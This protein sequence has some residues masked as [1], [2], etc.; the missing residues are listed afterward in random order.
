[1]Q[2]VLSYQHNI[3]NTND[4]FP[5]WLSTLLP[6]HLYD[7]VTDKKIT[8]VLLTMLLFYPCL[9]LLPKKLRFI[10]HLSICLSFCLQFHV[11]TAHRIFMKILPEMYL[12]TRKNWLNFV[13]HSHM[14]PDLGMFEEL[15]H[16]KMGI[17][18]QSCSY[19]GNNLP[20]LHENF[21]HEYTLHVY[22]WTKKSPLTF[23]SHL[24]LD[25]DFGSRLDPRRQRSALSECSGE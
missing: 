15:Q 16:C 23:G 5:D 11:E 2:W 17:F 14:D 21:M 6:R 7:S 20:D 4:A 22:L 19:L 25:T 10:R 3:I 1:M 9:L 18:S 12:W 8:V 13:S 24:D